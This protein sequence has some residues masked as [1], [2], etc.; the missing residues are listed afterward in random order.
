MAFGGNAPAALTQYWG[1]FLDDA[2]DLAEYYT[3]EDALRSELAR[4]PEIE[5]HVTTAVELW[6]RA[7]HG[8][9]EILDSHAVQ[10]ANETF[11]VGATSSR[12]DSIISEMKPKRKVDISFRAANKPLKLKKESTS[13][14]QEDPRKTILDVWRA[15]GDKGLKWIPAE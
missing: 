6:R 11:S 2:R 15:V 5:V 9:E 13:L 10:L 3:S 8:N 12:V 1:K 4:Q 7:R 14:Q